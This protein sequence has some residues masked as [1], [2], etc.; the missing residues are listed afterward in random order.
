MSAL[1]MVRE[2]IAER[3]MLKVKLAEAERQIA[4][5]KALEV[6]DTNMLQELCNVVEHQDREIAELKIK[7]TEAGT[8]VKLW[9]AIARSLSRM[10]LK[11]RDAET[12]FGDLE[13]ISPEALA[14][15]RREVEK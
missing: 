12:A 9:A 2:I 7:L 3:D 13:P 11:I 14:K 1:E 8:R 5:M 4:H 10:I 6:D 15:M